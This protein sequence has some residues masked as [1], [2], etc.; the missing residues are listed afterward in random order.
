MGN[1]KRER[2]AESPILRETSDASAPCA[3]SRRV[4][5]LFPS[6]PSQLA[7]QLGPIPWNASIAISGT[8]LLQ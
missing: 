6:L 4:E 3:S 7:S 1:I 2:A 8:I 5:D